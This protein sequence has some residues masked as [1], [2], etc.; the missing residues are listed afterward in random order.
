M[1]SENLRMD[2][3]KKR[4]VD[5]HL[6]ILITYTGMIRGIFPSPNMVA[7]LEKIN[8]PSTD[9]VITRIMDKISRVEPQE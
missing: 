1:P 5:G 9:S 6:S 7:C 8:I 3:S 2:W 4:L